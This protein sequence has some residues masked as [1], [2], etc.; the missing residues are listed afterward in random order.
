MS[1]SVVEWEHTPSTSHIV[2][3]LSHLTI[4]MFLGPIVAGFLTVVY[5]LSQGQ[6]EEPLV[7]LAVPGLFSILLVTVG[8]IL[9]KRN[10]QHSQAGGSTQRGDFQFI[11]IIV[12]AIV[13][14]FVLI[15]F[16]SLGDVAG[17]IG[18]FTMFLAAGI[19]LGFQ[20]FIITKGHIDLES[21]ILE[22]RYKHG[23]AHTI[24]L[25]EI[26]QVKSIVFG[27][28]AFVRFAYVA[29][30][31]SSSHSNGPRFLVVS[32]EAFSTIETIID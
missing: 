4:G 2:R 22:Y 9:T 24:D 17:L 5:M 14:G 21:G 7:Y 29:N 15:G 27:P 16:A 1:Q 32:N 8:W 10:Q 12:T 20:S 18:V 13:V 19:G 30:S 31:K 23:G 26:E 6:V 3:M 25:T 28:F 11:W